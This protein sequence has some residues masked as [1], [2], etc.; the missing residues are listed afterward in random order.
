M[1]IPLNWL[2]DYVKL[3]KSQAE[4][5]D[6]LT[7]V[8]HMLNKQWIS[9]NGDKVVD[10]ELRGNRS[11][12][13][14]VLGVAREVSV[15]WSTL[16]KLPETN[17]LPA[18]DTK[19]D[20][21]SVTCPELVQRFLAFKLSVEIGPSPKWLSDRLADFGL[22]SINN[23]VDITN[24]VMVE[25][26]E[27]MHAY[28]TSK[29][30]DKKLIVRRAKNGEKFTTLL[31][32]NVT[33]TTSDLAVCDE[34][35]VVGLTMIGGTDSGVD[36]NTK[37]I[38][39]EAAV[40]DQANVRQTARKLNIFTEA[41]TRHE[42]LLDP[43]QV[44]FA[45]KRALYLLIKLAKASIVSKTCDYYPEKRKPLTISLPF[46]EVRRMSSVDVPLKDQAQILS[47]LGCEVSKLKDR[48][49]VVA[50]TFRTDIVQT[51][52]LVEEVIRIYGYEK[53]P[54]TPLSGEVPP[55]QTEGSIIFADKIRLELVKNGIN[56]V[57]TSVFVPTNPDSIKIIN[58]PDPGLA[59]LRTSLKPNLVNYIKKSLGFRVERVALFEIGKI[60]LPKTTEKE[61]LIIGLSGAKDLNSWNKK[62]SEISVYDLIGVLENLFDS[63]GIDFEINKNGEIISGSNKLGTIENE[64]KIYLAT[65]DL[66]KTFKIAKSSVSSFIAPTYPPVIEDF[67]FKTK[68]EVNLRALI[69]QVKKLNKH[70]SNVQLLDSFEN[71][72]TIRV[73][74][75]SPTETLSEKEIAPIR[76][77]IIE[78][79]KASGVEMR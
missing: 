78:L 58:A 21:V 52:D 28:D 48:F 31:G 59:S 35:R 55:I 18:T 20:L 25:T 43:N 22:P 32:V 14:G 13:F 72:R 38:I 3:P 26:G 62:P 74:F 34:K 75:Q 42:K 6:R 56:E 45:L 19:S 65:I 47:D 68:D 49:S 57:I 36:Q 27:P 30:K 60:Y 76:L 10:L 44:E 11:D 40:Y 41:G 70:I 53:I 73:E 46:E 61:M 66:E 71:N 17:P 12:L 63:L 8:G 77:R 5:T 1:N 79:L 4:L 51:A 7:M 29:L 67:S 50:P 9:D 54:L 39:L 2:A 16:L 64:Q 69:G 23:V 37:E 24:Y 15:M 33:L